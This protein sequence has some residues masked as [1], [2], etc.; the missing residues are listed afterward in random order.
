ML[1]DPDETVRNGDVGVVFVNGDDATLKRVYHEGDSIR[2]HP[3]SYDVEYRD[4]VISSTDPDAPEVRVIG[5]V[6]SY[7]APDGWRA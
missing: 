2:L 1:I 7:T 6:V 4:R 5:K 3:E